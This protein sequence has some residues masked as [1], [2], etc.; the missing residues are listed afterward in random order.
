MADA[1]YSPLSAEDS[2]GKPLIGSPVLS[3]ISNDGRAPLIQFASS[4]FYWLDTEGAAVLEVIRIGDTSGSSEVSFTTADG[5]GK[6]GHAYVENC[7]RITFKP[8]ELSKNIEVTILNDQFWN[9]TTIF[10]VVL[11][12]EDLVGGLLDSHLY[13]TRV[14]KIDTSV[15]PSDKLKKDG[16][17]GRDVLKELFKLFFKMPIVRTG[18]IWCFG[19]DLLHNLVY[20]VRLFMKVYFINCII[21]KTG[22]LWVFQ[23]TLTRPR[24]LFAYAMM[25]IVFLALLHIADYTKTNS[26]IGGTTRTF[27]QS[28]LVRNYFHYSVSSRGAIGDGQLAKAIDRDV[29]LLVKG[30]TSVLKMIA[31]SGKLLCMLA[32]ELLAPTVFGSQLNVIH[33]FPMLV[34][35][36]CFGIFALVRAPAIRA[37]QETVFQRENEVADQIDLITDNNELM[38]GYDRCGFVSRSF[39]TCMK[40]SNSAKTQAGKVLLNTNYFTKWVTAI[41][42]AV[43]IYIGGMALIAQKLSV[44]MFLTNMRIYSSAGKV[45]EAMF[46]LVIEMQKMHPA[47]MS[48][49][50]M[51]NLET[52]TQQRMRIE[53]ANKDRQK[54][55]QPIEDLEPIELN[56]ESFTFEGAPK[57]CGLLNFK[58][59]IKVAQGQLVALVGP[60]GSGKATLLK[61]I[62]GRLLPDA[63]RTD[64]NSKTFGV[65]MPNHLRKVT[66]TSSP[67][68]YNGTLLQNITFGCV[69]RDTDRARATKICEMLGLSHAIPYFDSEV[70]AGAGI[71]S[72]AQNTVLQIAR[73]LFFN[74][75]VT[76]FHYPLAKLNNEAASTVMKAMREHIVQKGIA[77]DIGIADKAEHRRPRTIFMASNTP[78]EADQE[79]V[80]EADQVFRI[81]VEA[82]IQSVKADGSV[83]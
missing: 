23:P 75:E 6:A 5:S 16:V 55:A 51:L 12:S 77:R 60:M 66:V 47:A 76:C 73:A 21:K 13:K 70:K 80:K 52:D 34:F 79:V 39:E 64:G 4:S 8:G 54:A 25:E 36:V 50:K 38:L 27:L 74:A 19:V 35:P 18:T 48:M 32:F 42:L 56:V 67:I 46:G 7:G 58:G 45:F 26:K 30:Y 14:K 68:F 69:S 63:S 72:G 9:P 53:R 1:G 49:Y 10:K 3:R 43:Y 71:F 17:H 61:L 22:D 82:G 24:S 59:G 2:E 28:A 62:G 65:Y 29:P 57:G 41:V 33:C 81:S 37:V 31:H 78:S 83:K 11:S 20:F 44:G 40:A 15:F